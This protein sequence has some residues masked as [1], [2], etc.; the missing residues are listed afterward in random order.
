L[1][2]REN[3]LTTGQV[4]F[5]D[6]GTDALRRLDKPLRINLKYTLREMISLIKTAKKR[7]K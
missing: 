4:I 6:G 2:S 5:A 3:R 1:L 7:E